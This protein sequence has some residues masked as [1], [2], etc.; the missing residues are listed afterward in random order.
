MKAHNIRPQGAL[1]GGNNSAS[2][3][4]TSAGGGA[5]PK[6]PATPRSRR[7]A[8][9][10]KV[11]ADSDSDDDVPDVKTEV[12]PEVKS[13][14]K[15]KV[16]AKDPDDGSFLLN[17]ISEAPPS[18]V[19]MEERYDGGGGHVDPF[20]D[21]DVCHA[22]ATEHVV[23]HEAVVKHEPSVKYEPMV[24]PEPGFGHQHMPSPHPRPSLEYGGAFAHPMMMTPHAATHS[25]GY[26]TNSGLQMSTTTRS[27]MMAPSDGPSGVFP[28]GSWLQAGQQHYFWDENQQH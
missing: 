27:P 13:E 25:F 24:K 7:P 3:P 6:T 23:K 18:F 26:G 8:K 4:A 9:K 12:K 1:A 2:S 11:Q 20:D 19:K 17:D 10:R 28:G 22:C 5:G 15:P 16:E 14:K 21:L